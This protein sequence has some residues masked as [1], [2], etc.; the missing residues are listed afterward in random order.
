MYA[1]WRGNPVNRNCAVCALH[2][3]MVG[4]QN[5]LTGWGEIGYNL[6][7]INYKARTSGV[8]GNKNTD[9]ESY[10]NND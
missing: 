5:L 4:V 7:D 9:R 8:S 2:I 10:K 3:L 1:E 6:P